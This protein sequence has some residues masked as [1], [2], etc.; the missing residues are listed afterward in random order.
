V[1]LSAIAPTLLEATIALVVQL[2][3]KELLISLIPTLLPVTTMLQEVVFPLL[4]LDYLQQL[5]FQQPQV[6]SKTPL[7]AYLPSF[8]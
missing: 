6:I 3:T 4:A 5:Q 1:I 7:W 8:L 2:D